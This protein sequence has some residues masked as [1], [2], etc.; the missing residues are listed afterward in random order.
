MAKALHVPLPGEGW[1]GDVPEEKIDA[2]NNTAETPPT[3]FSKTTTPTLNDIFVSGTFQPERCHPR[4]AIIKK[5]DHF[6]WKHIDPR[7]FRPNVRPDTL[8]R[9]HSQF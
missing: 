3:F 4:R 5:D 1:P 7:L 6:T 2:S 8:P 9:N